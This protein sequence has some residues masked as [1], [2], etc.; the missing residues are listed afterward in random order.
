MIFSIQSPN[1]VARLKRVVHNRSTNQH[2]LPVADFFLVALSSVIRDLGCIC[3][4]SVE[5]SVTV[6]RGISAIVRHYTHKTWQCASTRLGTLDG[7]LFHVGVRPPNLIFNQSEIEIPTAES[8]RLASNLKTFE[9]LF[10]ESCGTFSAGRGI[11]LT[12]L[13][14]KKTTEWLRH[15]TAARSA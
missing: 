7:Q 9:C 4:I 3:H 12:G 1:F 5:K 2:R 8:W 10:H 11:E 14:R 6:V 13:P 15:V